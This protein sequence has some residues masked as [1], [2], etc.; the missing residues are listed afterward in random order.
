M[1]VDFMFINLKFI[2]EITKQYNIQATMPLQYW[3][4][5]FDS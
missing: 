5:W 1:N 3:Q 2:K 4:P